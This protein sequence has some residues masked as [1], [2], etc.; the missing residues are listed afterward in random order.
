M[1]DPISPRRRRMVAAAIWGVC[2]SLGLFVPSMAR[3]QACSTADPAVNA[4]DP[5]TLAWDSGQAIQTNFTNARATEGCST[6]LIVPAGYDAMSPQQQMLSLFNSERNAR[7]LPPLGLDSTLMSQIAVNH[8]QEMAQYGYF[9]HSSPINQGQNIGARECVNPALS[10]ATTGCGWENIAAGYPNAAE[11]VYSYMYFDGPGARNGACTP[12][13]TWGCWGHR[14]TVLGN[15]NWVGIGIVLN[16]SGSPWTNYYTDDFLSMPADYTPPAT[17]DSNPPVMGQISYSNGAA[18]VT[19]VADSPMNV[20]D[21]GTN[22]A[23]AGITQVVFYTNQI[24]DINGDGSAYNTVVATET[25]PGSGTW[26]ATITV[27][28]GDVLHAVAV[29]GSGNY[30]DMTMAT[31]T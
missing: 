17:A 7:G 20:N 13:V 25:T 19:G 11:A 9:A 1:V 12:T 5:V 29:N 10:K 16:A 31:T 22:P 15:L 30:T 24:S 28:Q 27:N 4:A 18:T 8:S 3:A 14:H 6:A 2:F 21:Q 23:T 26:S